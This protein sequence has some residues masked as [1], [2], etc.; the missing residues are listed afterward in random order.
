MRR[1]SGMML[2]GNATAAWGARVCDVEYIAAYPITPQSEIVELLSKWVASGELK[3]KFVEYESEHSM[4]AGAGAASLAGARAFTATSSQGLAYGFENLFA[5]SGWRAPMVM[6][7]VS[8]GLGMPMTLQVD[9]TDVFSVRDTG[10]IQLHAETCQEILDFIILAY[11]LGEDN[12]VL[13]PVI[14]NMDGFFLSFT[15]EPVYIPSREEVM[16]FLPPYEPPHGI[17][18]SPEELAY[19]PTIILGHSYSY[20]R[21]QIHLAT[22]KA[23]EVFYEISKEFGRL[24]GRYYEPIEKFM[25]DDAEYVIVSMNSYTS[26]VKGAVKRLREE[27][28]KVGVLKLNMFRPFP[29][30]EVADALRGIKGVAVF[31][32]NLSPGSGGIIYPELIRAVYHMDERPKAILDFVGGLGGKELTYGEIRFMVKKVVEAYSD[33]EVSPYPTLLF[34]EEDTKRLLA[35]MEIAGKKWGGFR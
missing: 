19:A 8:R 16:E 32:L 23:K 3:A 22:L 24:F 5:L 35:D 18:F 9:N 7:N 17:V 4:L 21:Y 34:T 33:G 20:F 31:D 10:W 14:V 27:G 29:N 30:E 13:L 12:R 6:V 28:Y 26:V 25:M 11:R 15:R 1:E 2:T